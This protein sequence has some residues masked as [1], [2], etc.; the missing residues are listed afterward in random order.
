VFQMEFGSTFDGEPIPSL[1]YTPF[2]AVNDPTV[3]KTAY[4]VDTYVD[5]EG[6][7][8]GTL[9]PKYDFIK[10]DK[11]QPNAVSIVGG[12][13]FAIWG[14]MV[15]GSDSYGGLPDTVVRNNVTGSFFTVSLQYE[16]DGGEPFVLDTALLEYSTED[17][18]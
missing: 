8:A 9:T 18:K 13:S 10:P 14:T 4:A 16:F 3:R 7:V 12:G 17:R 15:W 5:P 2:M 6:A 11:I 1:F